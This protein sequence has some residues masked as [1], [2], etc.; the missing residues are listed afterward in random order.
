[1]LRIEHGRREVV[2]YW[3]PMPGSTFQWETGNIVEKFDAALER[4]VRR[5]LTAGRTGIFLSGG[6]DS[7]SI[8]ALALDPAQLQDRQRPLALS[9]IFPHEECDEELVQRSVG[10]DLGLE[11]LF[12]TFKEAVGDEGLVAAGLRA[13]S[14]FALPTLNIW[15]PAYEYLGRQGALR[16]CTT[17]LNGSGGDEWLGVTP[18]LAADLILR[19]DI[20]GLVRLYNSQRRSYSTSSIAMLRKM[21]WKFGMQPILAGAAVRVLRRTAPGILRS[22]KR[23]YIRQSTRD[24]VAPDA[25]LRHQ[26]DQRAEKFIED[27]KFGSFYAR[28]MPRTIG[29]QL[30]SIEAEATFEMSSRLGVRIASPY[31]DS[32]LV[33]LLHRVHPEALNRGGRSKGLVRE[34][35]AR[36]FP[37]LGFGAQKKVLAVAYFRETVRSQ[38]RQAWNQL[39]GVR[40]LESMGIVNSARLKGFAEEVL[41]SGNSRSSFYIWDA[42]NVESWARQFI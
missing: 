13:T 18:F 31:W 42:L 38:W 8:A 4:A 20:P 10:Q 29:H 40:A 25:A 28:E 36:R 6:L 12:V 39:G 22:R 24:W 33:E 23:K 35:V 3:N 21:I 34:S 37:H 11:H 16:G 2:Q 1:V 41:A 19:G 26:I 9:M 32:D 27:P 15:L 14:A 5:C 30:R 17:I 7:V